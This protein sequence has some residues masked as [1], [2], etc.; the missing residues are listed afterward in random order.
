MQFSAA[1]N[2]VSG[3]KVNDV[4]SIQSKTLKVTLA[5]SFPAIID[6][7]WNAN[8]NTIFGQEDKL[9]KVKINDE[10]YIP[11]IFCSN[12]VNS[13]DY[14]LDIP[15]IKVFI[16]IRIKVINNIVEFDVT[17]IAE[18]G[19][20]RVSTFEI[21]EHNLLSVR[22]TQPGAAFAGSRMY[23]AIKGSGDSFIPLNGNTTID[24]IPKD[25]LY[26]I[27]NT[28]LLSASIWS[29]SV[30]EKSDNSRVQKQTVQKNG[31][32]RTGIWSGSW[33]YRAQGMTS[34]DSL[35]SAKIVITNDANADNT[36][37]WQDGAIAFRNIMNNPQGCA[38]IPDLVVQR[39]PMN[40]ASQATNPFTKTLDETKRVYL[41]TDGLG[42]FVILKGYGSEGHDSKHPDYGDIGKRQGGAKDMELLC[43]QAL[44]YNAFMGVH[45]NGTESY[46]EAIAFNDSLINKSKPG[47]DWLDA[48]YFINKRY[49]ATS[50]N[51]MMRFKS[52]KD[53]VPSLQFIY[54][55]VWY[56]K[57]SWDSRK[58][59]CEIHSLGLF[60]AT[61]FP[62]D[63]E[64]DAVWNHW[65]VDYNY[66][67]D[68]LKGYGSQVARFIRN[69]QKDTWIGR[70]PLLGGTEMKDYEGWQGRN[71]YDSCIW[72][73]FQTDLPAKYLQHFP[74]LKWS[75]TEIRFMGNVKSSLAN[76]KRIITKNDKIVLNGD[77]YLL[78]WNPLTEEML[79]HWNQKGGTTSWELPSGWKSLKTIEL[80]LL[81]DQGRQFVQSLKVTNGSVSI[82]ADG[83][84]PYVLYKKKVPQRPAINW[85]EGTLVNDPGF[86]NGDLRSWNVEG[87]GA[88][89]KRNKPGQY[90]LVIAGNTPVTVSQ[91]I[92]SMVPG[93]YYASVYVSTGGGR[94]AY[95]GVGNYGGPEVMVYVDNSLWKNYIAADSK[96]DTNMQ[97]MYVF[98]NIPEGQTTANLFLRAEAGSFPVVFDDVR[99]TRTTRPPK[100]DSVF[101]MED[102]ENMTDGLYPFVKAP[103]GGV[104]DPRT[105]LAELHAPYTQKGWNGKPVDDVI[106]GNWSLKAHGEPTGLL[107]QTLPQTIRFV[108]GRTYTVTFKYEASGSDY[109]L[110]IGEGTVKQMS[111]CLNKVDA[112]ATSSFTF[113]ADETGNSWFGIEKINDK[114]TD[115]I[116]DDLIIT[117]NISHP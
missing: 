24:S 32:L 63:H 97:R 50:N 38:N 60:M 25:F 95:L 10:F 104:N 68:D 69:H 65:A 77:T 109:A 90:E 5:K 94:K 51:R 113:V 87:T 14:Q 12:T 29:N 101:F 73:T 70:N 30:T 91:T 3:S 110:V 8:G 117:E 105:H 111:V 15:E 18:S 58:A 64:Y 75:E 66:G 114:E 98:F 34:T 27:I 106:N 35:P 40:F 41:N 42:Q 116:L 4:F 52:L 79:Y 93:Y 13:A 83:S 36:I 57:G 39:I 80:Y 67:G 86:N 46:P 108:A 17:K 82:S 31:Y 7:R 37:D 81:T 55:D 1:E 107:L 6:Y 49:D 43:K 76:G 89:V 44:K 47:W 19:T 56:A 71:D 45:I 78:P 112:P 72:I 59:A 53:Q 48:S 9:T 62:Q 11:R 92:N 61:E 26:G 33:I 85:G 16:K 103:S 20:F 2:I 100:P 102:F 23:T 54:V 28:D 99:I 22:S 21:P 84:K 96:R 115:F 74:I 88:S